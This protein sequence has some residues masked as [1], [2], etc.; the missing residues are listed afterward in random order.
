MTII[1]RPFIQCILSLFHVSLRAVHGH[2]GA[3]P[4]TIFLVVIP[5][6]KDNVI[7]NFIYISHCHEFWSSKHTLKF[8]DWAMF[9]SRLWLCSVEFLWFAFSLICRGG[10]WASWLEYVFSFC[11]SIDTINWAPLG[12]YQTW[13]KKNM[14]SIHVQLDIKVETSPSKLL[15]LLSTFRAQSL[16]W[17][18]TQNGI[19]LADFKSL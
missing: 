13:L 15:S 2:T 16:G 11:I 19:N 9:V 6:W 18:K 7:W 14:V 12:M 4:L 3:H 10:W 1:C 8:Q 17:Q 5:Q